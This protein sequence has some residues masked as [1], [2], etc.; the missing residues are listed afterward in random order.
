MKIIEIAEIIRSLFL[1]SATPQA[2]LLSELQAQRFPVRTGCEH[3]NILP[4][5]ESLTQDIRHSFFISF[6]ALA[7]SFEL[8]LG[9][10]F[11]SV[12]A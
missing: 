12:L 5:V 7:T 2:S 10:L 1:R 8:N 9:V 3:Y 4:V 11:L 6:A